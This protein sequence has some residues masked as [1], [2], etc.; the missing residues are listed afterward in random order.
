MRAKCRSNSL[1][2]ANRNMQES[3]LLDLPDDALVRV[4][5]HL[6]ASTSPNHL[7]SR[8]YRD[9]KASALSMTCRRLR[10]LVITTTFRSLT[11]PIDTSIRANHTTWSVAHAASLIRAAGP[12]LTSLTIATQPLSRMSFLAA[13]LPPAAR[14]RQLDRGL[15]PLEP[16]LLLDT[17]RRNA[18][19]L[20]VL[21]IIHRMLSYNN[22]RSEENAKALSRLLRERRDILVAFE[23]VSVVP[24]VARAIVSALAPTPGVTCSPAMPALKELRLAD[25]RGHWSLLCRILIELGPRLDTLEISGGL[26]ATTLVSVVG[27][28]LDDPI[29]GPGPGNIVVPHEG[30][31][32]LPGMDGSAAV[33]EVGAAILVQASSVIA[34]AVALHGEH[35]GAARLLSSHPGSWTGRDRE[36]RPTASS[37]AHA[38]SSCSLLK[39]LIIGQMDRVMAPLGTALVQACT[40]LRTLSLHGLAGNLERSDC[41]AMML[42]NAANKNCPQLDRIDMK[43]CDLVGDPIEL[44]KAVGSRLRSFSGAFFWESDSELKTFAS[45]CPNVEALILR[46]GGHVGRSCDEGAVTACKQFGSN[47]KTLVIAN[48]CLE[49]DSFY[50]AITAAT[51]VKNL[52]VN[53]DPKLSPAT[54]ACI[55]SKIGAHIRVLSIAWS[56]ARDVDYAADAGNDGAHDTQ[57]LSIIAD[58]C[59]LLEELHLPM[60]YSRCELTRSGTIRAQAALDALEQRLPYLNTSVSTLNVPMEQ[61]LE[62]VDH[63]A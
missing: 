54:V 35:A 32:G 30:A 40:G 11:T 1:Q 3:S 10:A 62:V 23:H 28:D 63:V 22:D 38:A 15:T 55:L 25:Y 14:D 51:N 37:L 46:C 59:P 9:G 43:S 5:V 57:L 34:A 18:P 6:T 42:L 45:L 33:A 4:I 50:A 21:R 53:C 27:E 44:F 48:T 61:Q 24:R 12:S 58:H 52:E 47:L 20:R 31:A 39:T 56:T 2:L 26:A 41:V 60:L 17:V 16:A 13:F 19:S 7:S 36:P 8:A 49:A 29:P